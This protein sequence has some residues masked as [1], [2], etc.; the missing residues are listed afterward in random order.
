MRLVGHLLR[1]A[2]RDLLRCL[3]DEERFFVATGSQES[4]T[5]AFAL[6][7]G[8]RRHRATVDEEPTDGEEVAHRAIHVTSGSLHRFHHP[9]I[10]LAAPGRRFRD[11]DDAAA[12]VEHRTIRE[13]AADINAN[14]IGHSSPVAKAPSDRSYCRACFTSASVGR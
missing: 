7:D 4:G 8:I 11:R 10:L 5:H 6:D 13:G 1:G 2:P 12:V 14:V 3:A 9:A